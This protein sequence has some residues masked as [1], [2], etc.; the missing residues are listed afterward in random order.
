MNGGSLHPWIQAGDIVMPRDCELDGM[1][2]GYP[3]ST[4][5]KN[6]TAAARL[7]NRQDS[8]GRFA[9]LFFW[10]PSGRVWLLRDSR[11]STYND[12][13]LWPNNTSRH[14]KKRYSRTSWGVIFAIPAITVAINGLDLRAA[15]DTGSPITVLSP[16]AAAEVGAQLSSD[17]RARRYTLPQN[18]R[19][20]W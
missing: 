6:L 12:F 10:M 14:N 19:N 16:S 5:I 18:Q 7:G 11:W 4:F 13:I 9:W 2:E 8:R 1:L 20:W 15:I 3:K 17:I